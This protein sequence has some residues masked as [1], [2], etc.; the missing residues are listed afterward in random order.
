VK[1]VHVKAGETPLALELVAIPGI[2]AAATVTT[3]VSQALTAPIGFVTTD[4]ERV[5]T[6]SEVLLA[7][8][9]G[10]NGELLW[11]LQNSR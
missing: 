3:S 9:P 7:L 8:K 5:A 10:Q 6:V 4:E 1:G 11:P 2:F